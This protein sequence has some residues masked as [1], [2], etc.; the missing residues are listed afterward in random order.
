MA[1]RASRPQC[2][3]EHQ[4]KTVLDRRVN[5]QI[6][7]LTIKNPIKSKQVKTEKHSQTK[8]KT[9]K[10]LSTKVFKPPGIAWKMLLASSNKCRRR[11]IFR[12]RVSDS[13]SPNSCRTW[14]YL[15]RAKN[16]TK[17]WLAIKKDSTSLWATNLRSSLSYQAVCNRYPCRLRVSWRNS[18]A[19]LLRNS[20]RELVL[21]TQT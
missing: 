6:Q 15:L 3:A 5:R 18:T 17:A 1:N 8:R 11:K 10:L 14:C 19:I 20:L 4:K 21:P 12:L 7:A 2:K 9:S 13:W 16:I